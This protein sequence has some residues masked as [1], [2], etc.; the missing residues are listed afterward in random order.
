M[1]TAAFLLLCLLLTS[2]THKSDWIAAPASSC[3]SQYT[4]R[5]KT[6]DDPYQTCAAYDD[7]MN[8]VVWQTSYSSHTEREV[9]T[10]CSF[11]SWE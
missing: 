4:G 8:C 10:D 11:T 5:S 3:H 6:V 7:K 2:C 9:Q 1:K